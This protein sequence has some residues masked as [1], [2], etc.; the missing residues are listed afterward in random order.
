MYL[1]SKYQEKPLE[2]NE[3]SMGESVASAKKSIIRGTVDLGRQK[4]RKT[5]HKPA[6]NFASRKHQ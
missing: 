5:V 2:R 4:V 3:T 1:Y 6:A